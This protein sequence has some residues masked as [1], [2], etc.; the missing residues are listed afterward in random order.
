VQKR[1]RYT[2]LKSL[3][4]PVENFFPLLPVMEILE[5][6]FIPDEFWRQHKAARACTVQDLQP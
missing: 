2:N 1:G 3:K 5:I 6:L 4:V